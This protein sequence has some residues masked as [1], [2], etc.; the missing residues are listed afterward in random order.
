MDEGVKD[1][2]IRRLQ[3]LNTKKAHCVTYSQHVRLPAFE[4]DT[5]ACILTPTQTIND[6]ANCFC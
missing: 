1:M 6:A 2:A 3:E 4:L 5:G